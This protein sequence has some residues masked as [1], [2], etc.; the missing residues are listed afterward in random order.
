MYREDRWS[1]CVS[2]LSHTSTYTT[3]LSKATDYFSNMLLQRWEV[4]IRLKESKPQPGIELTTIRSLVRH[5]HHWATRPGQITCSAFSKRQNSD[6]SKLKE[7]AEDK[8]KYDEN[9]WKLSKMLENAVGKWEIARYKRLE[10]QT[11]K[12][13]G[14]FGKWLTHYHTIPH[15]GAIKIY[16]CGKHCIKW[17]NCL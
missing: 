5:A 13:K 2:W 14:L 9:G 7:F 1:T 11:H 3:F 10:L 12:N 16:S 8:F 17:K 4:K 6:S 15:F